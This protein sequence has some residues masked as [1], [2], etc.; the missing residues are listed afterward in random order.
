MPRRQIQKQFC[1]TRRNPPPP[2]LDAGPGPDG[3]V[4]E[5]GVLD[6]C[7]SWTDCVGG[8]CV[9]RDNC[10]AGLYCDYQPHSG[11]RYCTQI[12]Q[13]DSQCGT[14]NVCRD[15]RCTRA[16]NPWLLVEQC[17]PRCGGGVNGFYCGAETVDGGLTA[18]C[19]L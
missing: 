4:C 16:C 14:G 6:S 2:P 11:S 3:G 19:Q 7:M 1:T 13:N 15:N 5:R 9:T 18:Y 10:G 8:S 12:C 17:G